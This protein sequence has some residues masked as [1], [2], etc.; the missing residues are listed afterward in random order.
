MPHVNRNPNRTCTHCNKPYY[1]SPSKAAKYCSQRC[2]RAAALTPKALSERFWSKVDRGGDDECWEW[3]AAAALT[4]PDYQYGAFGVPGRGPILSHRMAWE[5]THGEITE[6]L[7]VCHHCDNPPC[8][9]PRHLFLGT[10]S[11]NMQDM[12]RKG[13]GKYQR[14]RSS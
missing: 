14:S 8:C 11:D 1:R 12:L 13:R 6:G 7:H 10:R 4:D 5:L 3:Q 9:N 2:R